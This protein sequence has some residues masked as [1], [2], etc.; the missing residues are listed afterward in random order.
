MANKLSD[1]RRSLLRAKESATKRLAELENE[2]REIKASL[3]S[4][5]AALKAL[6]RS[7]CAKPASHQASRQEIDIDPARGSFVG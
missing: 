4:L 5:D 1:A 2:R 3:K 6:G 7:A